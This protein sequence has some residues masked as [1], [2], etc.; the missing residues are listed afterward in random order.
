MGHNDWAE[1][2]IGIGAEMAGVAPK[3]GPNILPSSKALQPGVLVWG[4]YWAM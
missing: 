3:A 1:L 2:N 4:K